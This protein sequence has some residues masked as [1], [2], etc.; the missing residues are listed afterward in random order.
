MPQLP[1]PRLLL[2][3]RPWVDVGAVGATALTF[4][5]EQW[6]AADL[7]ELVR[8]GEFYDFTRYR[9]TIGTR[10]GER[11][12]TVP[13]TVVRWSAAGSGWITVHALEPHMRGEDF[14]DAVV[15]LIERLGVREYMMIGAMYG[16]VP[17]TR[18]AVLSGSA[19]MEPL[20]SAL[21]RAGVSGSTYEGPTTILAT[22]PERAKALNVATATMLVQL[23]AYTQFD[24]DSRGT[25]TLLNALNALFSLELDLAPILRQSEEQ[26]RGLDSA[27]PQSPQ[28][29]AWVRELESAY[30]REYGQSASS[31]PGPSSDTKLSPELERFLKE[32]ESNWDS[33]SG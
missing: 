4:L 25:W 24:T 33:N 12:V 31:S 3:L 5:E 23:P 10:D 11:H 16:P 32:L 14:S 22:I 2:V 6:A 15:E 7:G 30:D 17:H 20:K 29:A 26:Y 9:P 1:Y 21:E 18:P 28:M 27:V 8:P 13:N 19:T